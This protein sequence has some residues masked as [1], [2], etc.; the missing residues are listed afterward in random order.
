M[1]HVN[2]SLNP[3]TG[4]LPITVKFL[5]TAELKK[6]PKS[7]W[8]FVAGFYRFWVYEWIVG[9]SNLRETRNEKPP[10]PFS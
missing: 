1:H 4:T 2:T 6:Y 9:T 10:N 8:D 3:C 7:M 5:N